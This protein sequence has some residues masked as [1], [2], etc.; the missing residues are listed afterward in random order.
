VLKLASLRRL[1]GLKT[2]VC[3]VTG[4]GLKDPERAV[5]VSNT[6]EKVD[7]DPRALRSLILG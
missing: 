3:T 5:A 4:H 1:T 7:A 2:I 6:V